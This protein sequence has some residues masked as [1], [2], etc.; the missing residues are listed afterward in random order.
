MA[1]RIIFAGTPDVAVPT[2][3]ALLQSGHTIVGVITREPKRRGRSHRFVPSEVGQFAQDNGLPLLET[4]R[5]GSEEARAW[6][7]QRKADLGVVVAYGALLPQ[8]V[9]DLLPL[10]WIN[11]HFSALPHLR[12]AAPVQHALLRG[13][14]TIGCSIFRLEAGMDTG[15]LFSTVIHP[16]PPDHTSGEVL[17]ELSQVGATQVVAVLDALDAETAVTSPQDEGEAGEKITY[18]PKLT[19]HDAFINFC[20]PASQVADHIRAVTPAPGAWTVLPDGTPLK[21]GPVKVTS[22]EDAKPG[23]VHITR[24]S[25]EVSCGRGAVIL[26]EVAPAG[27]RWMSAT[28]WWRGAR[29]DATIRLGQN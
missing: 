16:I 10:G 11:L 8:S 21:L 22:L 19:R 4:E 23:A 26:G 13:D 24:K 28:D 20:A 18:A 15:P 27:K 17:A 29:L 25:V 5:P 2:L 1:L 7:A 12:G 14:S 6:I 9:L 3:A